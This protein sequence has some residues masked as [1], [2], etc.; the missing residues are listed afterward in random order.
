M[1]NNKTQILFAKKKSLRE[2]VDSIISTFTSEKGIENY[3]LS[4]PK[5]T[6][7]RKIDIS[8]EYDSVKDKILELK[9]IVNGD[10]EN[11]FPKDAELYHLIERFGKG[12][13]GIRII[14]NE[15]IKDNYELTSSTQRKLEEYN[16]LRKRFQNFNPYY[17]PT[18]VDLY[19]TSD[20]K[21][22]LLRSNNKVGDH[23]WRILLTERRPRLFAETRMKAINEYFEW[24]L[25]QHIPCSEWGISFTD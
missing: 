4:L 9:L 22:L 5:S 12:E 15:E 11:S 1:A 19:S 24:H 8:A 6:T 13:F 14:Q 3:H 21:F 18:T 25:A 20:N 7:E 16:S 17:S 23:S 2:I 10:N